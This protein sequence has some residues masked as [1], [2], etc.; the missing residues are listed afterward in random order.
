MLLTSLKIFSALILTLLGSGATY[1]HISTKLDEKN[2]L[3][4]GK[5]VDIGGYKLHMVDQGV[6]GPTVV[7][8]S[9]VK[10]NCLD[11]SLV[12]P[13]IAKFTRVV[14]YDRAGYAWSDESPLDR[15]SANIVKELRTMLKNAGVPG[16]YILVGHSFGG[17]NMQLFAMTYPDEVV[18][19]VLVDAVH[20]DLLKFVNL[21]SIE[22]FQLTLCGVYLGVFRLL[23]HIPVVKEG[24]D[25]QIEKFSDDVKSI[26][27]SQSMTTKFVHAVTAEAEFAQESCRQLE[28]CGAYFGDMPLT[29][30]TAEKPLMIYEEVK[31]VY[32]SKEVE[33]FNKGWM[34]LQF[35]LVTKSSRAQHIIAENSGHA[36]PIDRPDV[37]IDAVRAM[38]DELQG[39]G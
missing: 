13:E 32:T 12:Q 30:I 37:I 33:A 34:N 10:C 29:V 36:V 5:M 24:L 11:W 27:Y 38:V 31:S 23:T 6:G 20:S 18:G 28:R 39:Q 26:Y 4:I 7:I 22:I 17:N 14:T 16:P 2:Y 19:L 35:D 15:T 9:G 3:P 8:D 21:P 25:K 1:Q